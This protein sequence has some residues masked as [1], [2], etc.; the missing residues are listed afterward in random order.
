MKNY[1][2]A[3]MAMVTMTALT[4]CGHSDYK[5]TTS[6][7]AYDI[8]HDG[9]GENLK[10]GDLIKINIKMM[11]G[12]SVVQNTYTHMPGYIKIDSSQKGQ[13]NFMEILHELKVGD[14]VVVIHSLDSLKKMGQ[15]PPTMNYAA[16]TTMKGYL[17]IVAG[18]KSEADIEADFKRE[19]A[20]EL[21]RESSK[22]E[23]YLKDKN[24]SAVKTPKG[25]FVQIT[26]EG[27]GDIADTGKQVSVNY[28]GTTLEGVAFDSN[29]DT[30]FGHA[31]APFEFVIGR[32][33]VVAG[34]VECL[35]YFRQ[36]SKGK[37]FIPAMLGYKNQPQSEVLKAYTDLIF[38]I[39]LLA[40]K[41]APPTNN[42]PPMPGQ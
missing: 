30:A 3:G 36:G 26:T 39:E 18:F 15:L 20:A 6:G 7:L 19:E 33:P 35:K 21:V 34:W 38:D 37:M 2:L 17:K 29:I 10:H 11:I 13:H 31:G 16:G 25:A 24:I 23:K 4:S 27:T 22:L 5:K 8:I 42:T 14:S 32:D 41:P 40:V 1:V 9:K 12:D 28:H